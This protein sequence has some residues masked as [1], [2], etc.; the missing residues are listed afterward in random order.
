MTVTITPDGPFSVSE[1][2]N[3]GFSA[4]MAR[5]KPRDDG[6]AMAFTVDGYR[7][8]A[9]A[10]LRQH[11][12]T[13]EVE[14]F[15]DADPDAALRQALR[16]VSLDAPARDWVEVGVADPVLGGLQHRFPGLRPVLFYSPYEAAAWSVISQRRQRAQAA[17]VR[18]RISNAYGR[19]FELPD[20]PLSAFPLPER[21]LE[22]DAVEGLDE[23]RLERLKGVARA[24]LD[25]LLDAEALATAEPEAALA[26]LQT[27]TGIGPT[28]AGLILLRSTGVRDIATLSEPRLAAYVRHFWG[29]DHT[30]DAEELRAISDRWSPYRTWAGVL[31]RTAGDREGVPF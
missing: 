28:Y 3:F 19:R 30:P 21:L 20:A 11:G 22:L 6:M 24:A 17:G 2:A 13:V 1:A 5:P 15:G 12:D 27:I 31:I 14:L 29:L 7:Q 26:Q 8:Q 16:V 18:T 4:Q 23:T 10:Y 25:G 9:G